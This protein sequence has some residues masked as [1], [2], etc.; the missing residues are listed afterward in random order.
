MTTRSIHQNDA[1][2]YSCGR[3][4]FGDSWRNLSDSEITRRLAEY[5]KLRDGAGDAALQGYARAAATSIHD[6]I[7]RRRGEL[8]AAS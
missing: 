3:F 5:G 7:S 4:N 8:G 1:F 2:D 6:E